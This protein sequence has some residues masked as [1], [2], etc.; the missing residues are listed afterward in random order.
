[1]FIFSV[2]VTATRRVESVQDVPI[3]ISV[4]GQQQMDAQGVKASI[5]CRIAFD[6]T[7]IDTSVAYATRDVASIAIALLAAI[8]PAISSARVRIIDGLRAVT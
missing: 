3:S 5:D 8:A 4:F 6:V 7:L 1:M 2:I